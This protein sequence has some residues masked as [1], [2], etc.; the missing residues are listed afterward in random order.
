MIRALIYDDTP[1]LVK[2]LTANRDLTP[3]DLFYIG[4]HFIEEGEELRPFATSL[5]EYVGRRYSK[6]KVAVVAK[7]KLSLFRASQEEMRLRKKGGR[8]GVASARS[9]SAMTA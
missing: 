2:R 7:Q 9:R 1:G 3:E 8:R 6:T 4:F 5:L